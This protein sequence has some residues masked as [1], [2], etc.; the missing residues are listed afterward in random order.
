MTKD[1]THSEGSSVA[2]RIAE[3][4]AK[5]GITSNVP[6]SQHNPR[7]GAFHSFNICHGYRDS[8]AW[9]EF[10]EFLHAPS[11]QYHRKVAEYCHRALRRHD[12][13]DDMRETVAFA[14][15]YFSALVDYKIREPKP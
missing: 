5:A 6:E 14:W 15:G 8:K 11:P 3:A 10:K 7:I 13:P 1:V 12:L 4:L 2:A 9:R